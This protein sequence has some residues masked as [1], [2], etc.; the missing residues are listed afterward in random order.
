MVKGNEDFE[1]PISFL[2]G[3]EKRSFSQVN[4]K[5]KRITDHASLIWQQGTAEPHVW[6]THGN[7]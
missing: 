5:T 7:Y 1:N 3:L 6:P 4:L 2:H